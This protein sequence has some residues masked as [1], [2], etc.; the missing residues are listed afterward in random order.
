MEILLSAKN[1]SKTF[2]E[3][4]VLEKINIEIRKAEIVAISGA[5]G[6]G[7]TTL[8]NILSTLDR[9]DE[10]NSSSLFI[11]NHEVFDLKKNDLANFRNQKIGFVFQF[12]EL[13][14]EL[15]VIENICLP[16]WIKKDIDVKKKAKKL[17]KYFGLQDFA[18]K[19]PLTLSGGEKQ[20]VAIARSLIND[21][22]IIFADEP[23]GNL[24]S[25]NSKI[26]FDL[27]FKL[28]DDYDC[29]VV[30][31]THDEN[32]ANKCDRKLLIVDGKIKN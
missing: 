18:D 12:H 28:R 9:P 3:K 5:S 21:P 6:A 11:D 8:L 31:V 27:F 1:I 19:K 29:S 23:T 7:K 20:R 10:N 15:N 4:R 30:I 16:G 2:N 17:L 32:S 13:I 24:D 14:P 25:K 26:L 22:K